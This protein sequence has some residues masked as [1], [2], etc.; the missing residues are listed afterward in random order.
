[1]AISR[2]WLALGVGAL[3][4]GIGLLVARVVRHGHHDHAHGAPGATEAALTS[5]LSLALRPVQTELPGD[6]GLGESLYRRHCVSCHGPGGAG[7]GPAAAGLHPPPRDHTDAW[8][9]EVRADDELHDLVL[10]G[11][12]SMQRSPL[13]PGFGDALDPLEGW[14]LVAYLRTLPPRV[15]DVFPAAASWTAREVLLP[16]EAA[17]RVAGAT[18]SPAAADFRAAWLDVLDDGGALLGRVSFPRALVGE[19]P[20]RLV[21]AVDPDGRPLVAHTHGLLRSSGGRSLPTDDLLADAAPDPVVQQL[22]GIARAE[23]AKLAEGPAALAAETASADA[24]RARWTKEPQAFEGG[25]LLFQQLCAHCHGATGQLLGAGVQPQAVR[26]RNL[27]DPAFH[28]SVDD[29]HL[30]RL[31]KEGG[32]AAWLS[33][34]MPSHSHLADAQLDALVRYVRGLSPLA[35]PTKEGPP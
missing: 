14:A 18:L 6:A 31:I 21:V 27:A 5:R 16:H 19:L 22:A 29:A 32:A 9:M 25:V 2:R 23:L 12:P 24:L 10:K 7:D 30:R 17:A 35:P 33:P 26:P 4:L 34:I 3:G 11:G 28:A 20:V 8:H 15:R 13:M 1:M